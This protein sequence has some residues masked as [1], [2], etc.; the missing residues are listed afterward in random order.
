MNILGQVEM[1]YIYIY[2]YMHSEENAN[3]ANNFFESKNVCIYL[4]MKKLCV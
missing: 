1:I 4:D 2:I 3:S